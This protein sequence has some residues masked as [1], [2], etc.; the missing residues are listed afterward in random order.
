MRIVGCDLHARQQTIA[1]VDTA[2]GEF[3]EKTLPR[4]GEC[5]T[6]VLRYL[7]RSGGGRKS[8][9]MRWF[10]ELLEELGTECRDKS[11]SNRDPFLSRWPRTLIRIR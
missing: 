11:S 8:Q 2:T 1:M 9:R 5:G 3:I 4:E 10:L 7:I 6:R